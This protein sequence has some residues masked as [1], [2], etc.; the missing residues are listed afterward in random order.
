MR[1]L[2]SI[3]FVIILSGCSGSNIKTI[4][5]YHGPKAPKNT[6]PYYEPNAAYASSNAIWK[7]PIYNRNG[8][9]VK[10]YD[11]QSSN[12]RPDYEHASWATGAKGRDN[13]KPDGTF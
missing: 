2:S 1:L 6:H 5:S 12:W 9:I 3:L 13:L 11:P 4:S 10:P 7:A 8:T